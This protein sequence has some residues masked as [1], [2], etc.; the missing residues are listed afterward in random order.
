MS[1][2]VEVH[3]IEIVKGGYCSIHDHKKVN[4]FHVISGKVKVCVWVDKKLVDETVIKAGE[5]TAVPRDLEHQFEG[6]EK[7]VCLE[8][9]YTFLEPGDINRR[10]GSQGGV[11]SK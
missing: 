2:S 6:L 1:Q 9:Y 11:K 3:V 8:I 5:S 4:M 10:L 7:S